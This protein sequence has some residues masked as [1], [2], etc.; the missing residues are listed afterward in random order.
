MFVVQGSQYGQPKWVQR[1]L[2]EASQVAQAQ[3]EKRLEI[4]TEAGLNA[5]AKELMLPSQ[6]SRD[7]G[8]AGPAGR[9]VDCLPRLQCSFALL[10]QQAVFCTV[11]YVCTGFLDCV[12]LVCPGPALGALA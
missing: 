3:Q 1:Y 12:P 6:V 4:G 11:A 10:Q 7:V 2:L 5:L 9:A 8:C